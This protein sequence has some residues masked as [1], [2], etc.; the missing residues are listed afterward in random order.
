MPRKPKEWAKEY[1]HVT[2]TFGPRL[3]DSMEGMT[4]TELARRSGVSTSTLSNWIQGR[5]VPDIVR[6]FAVI[7]VLNASID[8]MIGLDEDDAPVRGSATYPQ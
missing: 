2:K 1:N 6:L 4:I 5:T 3:L 8:W 7:N